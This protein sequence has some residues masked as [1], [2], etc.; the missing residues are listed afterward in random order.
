MRS[1]FLIKILAVYEGYKIFHKKEE[2]IVIHNIHTNLFRIFINNRYNKI[3]K[4]LI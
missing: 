2:P 1:N 3:R 4:T